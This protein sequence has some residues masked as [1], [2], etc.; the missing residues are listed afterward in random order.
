ARTRPPQAASPPPRRQAP[1]A[2]RPPPRPCRRGPPQAWM[3][4]ATCRRRRGQGP[5]AAPSG[6]RRGPWRVV[7]GALTPF[8]EPP[9]P[10]PSLGQRARLARGLGETRIASSAAEGGIC[11]ETAAQG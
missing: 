5:C 6:Q 7:L 11:G 3:G 4:P 1:A 8:F 9:A 2:A 10:V